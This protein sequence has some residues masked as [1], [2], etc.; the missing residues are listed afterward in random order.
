[1]Y[2]QTWNLQPNEPVALCRSRAMAVTSTDDA[3]TANTLTRQARRRSMV[4]C[5]VPQV[6]ASLVVSM[7]SATLRCCAA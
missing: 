5:G 4:G 3:S 7:I 1:M 2:Q 6:V